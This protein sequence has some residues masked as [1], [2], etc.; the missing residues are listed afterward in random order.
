[1]ASLL[2]LKRSNTAGDTPTLAEGELAINVKDEQLFN[3]NST[4][5]FALRTDGSQRLGK[6]TGQFGDRELQQT[7]V[8]SVNFYANAT[9]F[10]GGTTWNQKVTPAVHNAALANTNA[11]IISAFGT[12]DGGSY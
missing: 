9:A 11:F 12:R 5:T 7:V 10:V 1:M 3:A 6:T 8:T 2:K 4:A